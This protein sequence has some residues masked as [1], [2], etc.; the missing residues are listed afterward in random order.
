MDSPDRT[1]PR[2]ARSRTAALDAARALL[3]EEGPA[4]VTH[5]RVAARAGVGRA[6]VY[7]HWPGP[8]A[9]LH[10]AM[11]Q[12]RL[13][14]FADYDGGLHEWLWRELRRLADELALP[15]VRQVTTTLLQNAQWDPAA[16]AQFDRWVGTTAQRLHAAITQAVDRGE[17][18]GP[19]G[20]EPSDVAAR[21]LGPLVFRA[22]L[23]GGT[24]D[25][26]LLEQ[27]LASV[28]PPSPGFGSRSPGY[29]PAVPRT[30]AAVQE[31]YV[32]DRC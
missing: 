31:E 17:I 32:D 29:P 22:V 1:D 26:A 11:E 27:V 3:Q 16:R 24:V 8:E 15:A 21:L 4:A 20:T 10:E 7:R 12:V 19:V 14:F 13:P 30:D 25:D 28:V 18:A 2:A 5:Q 6:T 9:L 23:Q